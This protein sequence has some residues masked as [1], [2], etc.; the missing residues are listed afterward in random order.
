VVDDDDATARLPLTYQR[1]L[2]LLGEGCTQEEIAARLA[3]DPSA[4]PALV[5]LA[6]AKQARA[7]EK[8][9]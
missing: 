5:E 8:R 2:A 9:R 4:V 6:T 3:I 7:T 1:V